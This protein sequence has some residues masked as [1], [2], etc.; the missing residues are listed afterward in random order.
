MTVLLCGGYSSRPV[1]EILQSDISSK[2]VIDGEKLVQLFAEND[3]F[4]FSRA[5]VLMLKLSGDTPRLAAAGE[6]L[7]RLA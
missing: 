5:G 1:R 4:S 3:D 6:I 2:P 7:N